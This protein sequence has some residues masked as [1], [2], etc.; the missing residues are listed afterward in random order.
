MYKTNAETDGFII[1]VSVNSYN[2]I[3]NGWDPSPVKRRDLDPEVMQF[4]ESCATDIPLRYPL[5][6][7]FYLPAENRDEEKERLSEEGIRNNFS[8]SIALIR[9]S[10]ADI[11]KKTMVYAVAAFAFLTVRYMSRPIVP[12]NLLTTILTEGLSIGGWVFLW[13]AFSLFFF[14]GQETSH[15]LKR[16]LR[17]LHAKILFKY[18]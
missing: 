12:A 4:I 14:A 13:E 1:E 5:E 6:L 10:L 11:R 17:L 16:F 18:R 9:R 8:Y 2:E 7:H 3:F 15:Q